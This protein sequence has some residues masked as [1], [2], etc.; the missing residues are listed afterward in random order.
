[1]SVTVGNIDIGSVVTEEYLLDFLILRESLSESWTYYPFTLHAFVYEDRVAARLAEAGDEHMEVHRLPGEAGSWRDNALRRIELVEHS[2]LERCIVTDADNV[3]LTEVPELAAFLAEH[4]LVF[5]AGPDDERPVQTA[6][7]AFR[8][9]EHSIEFAR[10]WRSRAASADPAE[11]CLLLAELAGAEREAIKVVAP[12]GPLGGGRRQSPY[13]VDADLR[14]FRLTRDWLGFREDRMGRVKVLHLAGLRAAGHESMPGRMGALMDRFPG[15]APLMESYARL[16]NRGAA[17]LAIE[18]APNAKRYVRERLM[19]AGILP[20]RL[21]FPDFL[22]R[23]D[24]DGMGVEVGVQE[25]GFSETILQSWRGRKLISIDSWLAA[26]AD[27]YEDV[28]N[29]DQATHDRL[30]RETVERLRKFGERSEIWR[31]TSTEAAARIEP[32][33]LDFVYIDARHDYRSVMEDL[34]HWWDKVRPGGVLAGHDY[35]DGRVPHGDF[36]VKSAVDEFFGKRGLP[37][38]LTYADTPPNWLVE[39]PA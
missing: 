38:R 29:V 24:L 23:R 18:T 35:M 16:A 9:T 37:V 32:R 4:D 25:G 36:G 12:A 28:S 34:E 31:I 22:N 11:D 27:E 39:I 30:Y 5:V 33:T 7:W 17:R 20:S 19:A 15:V 8:R 6:L 13:G 2:G 14:P 10:H 21:W 26:S 1:M 3:F